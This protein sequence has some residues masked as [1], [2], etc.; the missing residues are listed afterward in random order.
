MRATLVTS[1]FRMKTLRDCISLL[2]SCSPQVL[3]R[4]RSPT[5]SSCSCRAALT[6]PLCSIEQLVFAVYSVVGT[7]RRF[8]LGLIRNCSRTCVVRIERRGHL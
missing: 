3:P 7:R 2:V 5:R 8:G 1:R 4:Y 6:P